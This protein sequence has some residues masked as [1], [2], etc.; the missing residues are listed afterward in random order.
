MRFII[1]LETPKKGTVKFG[2]NGTEYPFSNAK[3]YTE[4]FRKSYREMQKI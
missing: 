3:E 4:A 1:Y 2:D